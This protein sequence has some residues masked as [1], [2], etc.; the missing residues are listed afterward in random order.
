M[1]TNAKTTLSMK[2]STRKM[3][4]SN[5]C[6]EIKGEIRKTTFI[7][8]HIIEGLTTP[9][10]AIVRVKKGR[11]S[12]NH[13]NFKCTTG[14]SIKQEKKHKKGR[15]K[16][17]CWNRLSSCK[18]IELKLIKK[19]GSCNNEVLHTYKMSRSVFSF[20][21]DWGINHLCFHTVAAPS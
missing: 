11:R 19:N 17:I 4:L 3:I 15:K 6:K 21:H 7:Y 5:S 12:Y 14:A 1:M 16:K 20:P 8:T 13:L 10:P 9:T 18:V 2:H